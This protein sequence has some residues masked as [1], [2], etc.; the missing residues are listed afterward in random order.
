VKNAMADV[1]FVIGKIIAIKKK[2]GIHVKAQY[3]VINM[4]QLVMLDLQRL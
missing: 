4:Y 3:L 1:S 2:K